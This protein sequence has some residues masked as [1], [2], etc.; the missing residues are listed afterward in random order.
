MDSEVPDEGSLD[1]TYRA[2]L[3]FLA[4]PCKLW[5]SDDASDGDLFL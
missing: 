2:A 1:E 5:D 3:K 4:N